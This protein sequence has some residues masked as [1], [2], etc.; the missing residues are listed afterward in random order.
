MSTPLLCFFDTETTGRDPM[1]HEVI[2]V[3]VVRARA[4]TFEVVD[5]YTA[6]ICPEHIENAEPEA[7]AVNGYTP[8]KWEEALPREEVLKKVRALLYE[9][10]L[11]G[12][13]VSFDQSFMDAEL[14]RRSLLPLMLNRR[15]ILDTKT[16]AW[17]LLQ[18]GEV[19]RLSLDEL[20]RHFCIPRVNAHSALPDARF[21]LEIAKALTRRM[22]G[23]PHRRIL[24]RI[25]V[26]HPFAADPQGN[27]AKVRNIAQGLLERG[28]MPV[29]PHLYLPQLIDEQTSRERAL[30]ACVELLATCDELRVFGAHRSEGM[31][32]EIE[33][34][35]AHGIPVTYQEV[36]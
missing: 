2:E 6:K 12:H 24:R 14:H 22:Q 35:T 11:A 15:I 26:C 17:P 10:F 32:H 8:E 7:L 1:R 18:S 23:A 29:A 34:A 27:I 20:G 9:H 33:W 4:D 25:Y 3:G 36:M 21:T 28:V 16:L 19:S 31:K 5:E 13:Q 30:V